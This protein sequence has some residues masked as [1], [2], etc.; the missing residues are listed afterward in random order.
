[1]ALSLF[2]LVVVANL[3]GSLLPLLLAKLGIDPALIS[4]PLIATV[5]DISG[6][7]I[8]LTVAQFL[9]GL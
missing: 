3:A 4:N 9:L 1:M 7:L 8:Y 6:L 5:S 2:L